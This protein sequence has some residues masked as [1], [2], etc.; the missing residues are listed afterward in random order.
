MDGRH[1]MCKLENFIAELNVLSQR[2]E[3]SEETTPGSMVT[4]AM[5]RE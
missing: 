5:R 2:D 4:Q 1:S 3:E